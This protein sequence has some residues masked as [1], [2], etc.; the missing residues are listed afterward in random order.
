MGA[1]L[2]PPTTEKGSL[3]IIKVRG[4]RERFEVEPGGGEDAG[5]RAGSVLHPSQSG[6]YQRSELDDVVLGEVDQ[7]A[8]P[9]ASR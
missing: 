5:D 1:P 6:L 2:G 8:P 4:L 7:R 9:T 3:K